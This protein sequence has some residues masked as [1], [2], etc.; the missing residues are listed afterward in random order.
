MRLRQRPLDDAQLGRP[1]RHRPCEPRADRRPL[2]GAHQGADRSRPLAGVLAERRGDWPQ[3]GEIDIFEAF[4]G[5]ATDFG[6]FVHAGPNPNADIKR[7]GTRPL[8]SGDITGWHTYAVDWDASAN[9]H[10][11]F[12]VDGVVTQSFTATDIGP[13]WVHLQKPQALI[14]D[15]AVGGRDVK[16]PTAATVFPAKMYVDYI[17]VYQRPMR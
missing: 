7:G 13:S 12:S 2:R 6:Q 1:E 14:L 8:P 10:I 15:L 16:A 17:K 3:N 5:P 4:G 9:G 11:T